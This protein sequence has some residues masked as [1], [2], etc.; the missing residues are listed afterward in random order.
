MVAQPSTNPGSLENHMITSREN[1]PKTLISPKVI[2]PSRRCCSRMTLYAAMSFSVLTAPQ[3]HVF[4]KLEGPQRLFFFFQLF[5]NDCLFRQHSLKGCTTHLNP[6]KT[7]C[8]QSQASVSMRIMFGK[9]KPNQ[10]AKLI[11]SP[12]SGKSLQTAWEAL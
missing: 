7:N 6:M 11:T 1:R 5:Y 12:F 3:P 4:L 10:E 8:S 2:G 9:A